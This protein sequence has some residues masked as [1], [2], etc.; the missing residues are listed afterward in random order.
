MS[1]ILIGAGGW[2]YFQV[3]GMD[4]LEAYS[5][6]FDFVELN[7]SYYKLPAVSS[8][9]DWRKRVPDDFRFS[10]RC[11]RIIVDHY[12]LK[13]L[14]GSRGLLER[15]EEVCKQLNA[16]VM[17]VLISGSS[18]IKENELATRLNDFLG[19]FGSHETPVAVEFRGIRPSQEV[20]DVMKESGAIHSVDLSYDEPLYEGKI[21]YSRLFGKGEENIYEFDDRELK[22]IAK[23]ASEPKFEKSILAFH[24][25]RMYRDAGR[26]KSFIDKGYFPKIT[27]GVG[28]DSIREVLSEDSRFPTTK[29]RLLKDQGWKVFQDTDEVRKISTVLGKLP[30]GEFNTLDDLMAELRSQ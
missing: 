17:T 20:L 7:S 26:V 25:V 8:A 9:S 19:T 16:E 29:T 30:D 3:P 15:L 11:P 10:V 27:S 18:P 14:P 5:H 12:G 13:L 1:Q 6:S 21:L 22:E 4:S 28:T 2:A 24:G 23:K